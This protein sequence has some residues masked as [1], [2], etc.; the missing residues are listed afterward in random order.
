MSE[1]DKPDTSPSRRVFHDF[2]LPR[3]WS[4]HEFHLWLTYETFWRICLHFQI[5][6][7]VPI[8][9]VEKG[10]KC[11]MGNTQDIV[12]YEATFIGRLRMPLN[13]IT[14]DSVK[15]LNIAVSQLSPNAWHIF[16]GPKYYRVLWVEV[17]KD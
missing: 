13:R 3:D 8:R 6:D 7:D 16:V 1:G 11:Y 12:L 17:I 14:W 10:E 4:M 2:I 9:K 5:L 15:R